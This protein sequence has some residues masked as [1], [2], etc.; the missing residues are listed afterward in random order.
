[1]AAALGLSL[2][3]LAAPFHRLHR[4][5]PGGPQGAAQRGTCNCNS[6]FCGNGNC[7]WWTGAQS[8]ATSGIPNDGVRT[9]MDAVDFIPD[10]GCFDCWTSEYTENGVWGQVGWS[11]CGPANQ[12]SFTTFMQ[13]W[14]D[15]GIELVDQESSWI[16]A[17][18]HLFT[19]SLDAG[20]TW[21][22]AIDGAIFASYDMGTATDDQPSSLE[23]FCEEADG[24]VL[25]FNMP[26][27]S[28]PV[29]MEVS[30]GGVWSPVDTGVSYESPGNPTGVAGHA[31]DG[32][33]ADNQ[34]VIGGS[35]A[36]LGAPNYQTLWSGTSSAAPDAGIVPVTLPYLSVSPLPGTTVS[37]TVTVVAGV[38]MP[39]G[40]TI[41][42][43]QFYLDSANP[44][45]TVK[46][47]P[48][49]CVWTTKAGKVGQGAVWVQV[50]DSAG[51]ITYEDFDYLIDNG[52]GTSTSGG[53]STGG[54]STGAGASSGGVTSGGETGSSSG[55]G[56]R[57]SSGGIG[58]TSF[59]GAASSTTGNHTTG[60]EPSSSAVGNSSGGA[61][62]GSSTGE[63]SGGGT[64]EGEGGSGCGCAA[65]R[66]TSGGA[67]L[68]V[69][70]ALAFRCRSRR[71]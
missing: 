36:R 26:T 27:T 22:Y 58:S 18:P 31:Q 25:A 67:A 19:M 3:A 53:S 41:K 61:V 29:A 55:A 46:K 21:D 68:W 9:V 47:A 17:G 37:G 66:R 5:G 32:S 43:V 23:T 12:A 7:G 64:A 1:M 8:T 39:A 65:G 6:G 30:N 34:I 33:L 49:Q 20:T 71:K 14:S 59:S 11:Y 2:P 63:G 48:W 45:C 51:Q 44:V 16:T 50:N 62:G 24:V 4:L 42:S 35:T 38:T 40:L 60:G 52:T 28:V 56:S 57:T 70:V 15:A 69:L 10:A 54:T 13:V